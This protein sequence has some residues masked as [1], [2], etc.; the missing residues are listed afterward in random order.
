MTK[1]YSIQ[2]K[3][4]A[5]DQPKAAEIFIYGDIGESWWGESVTAAE[6]VKEIAALDADE[7]TVRINSYGGSVSDGVAIYNAIKRHKARVTIAIDGVAISIASLI[8][9]AGDTVE[10]A[11]NALMM[12]HAPWGSATGNSADMRDMADVLDKYAQAMATS[13]AAKSGKSIDDV[14]ALLSDGADHWLTATEAQADGYVDTVTAA[15]A[16]AASFDR[17]AFAARTQSLPPDAGRETPAAA[18]ATTQEKSMNQKTTPAADPQPAAT[19]NAD[20]I[21]AAAIKAEADRR[22][23]IDL[24]FSKFGHVAGMTD[25]KAACHKDTACTVEAAKLQIL[26]KIST[27]ATPAAGGHV[28]TVEDERD[29]FRAGAQAA[30][31]ARAGLAK[32]DTAN[33]FRGHTLLE[34]ARASLAKSGVR[35]DGM[36]KM[37]VVAAAFTHSTSD[38]DS[39]LANTANKAMLKGYEEAEETFQKWTSVGNLPDFKAA[40]RVDLNTF[41]SL[42]V[43]PEGAEYKSATFGDR[44]ETVQ[45]AT[46]G[47]KFS[48][49]RQAI[50]NDDLDAFSKIPRNMGRAA[51]R[52]VGNL[53]YAVLTANAAMADGVAL[54]HADHANLL[55]GAAI[56]T[57]SVDALAAAMRK[58]KDATGNTLNIRL[59]YLLVPVSLEGLA[60]TVAN[61]EFEVGTLDTT[62]KLSGKNNTVPNIMRGRFEVIGD[63]RLDDTST[64][65][66]YGAANAASH[67]TIEVSYLDGVQTPVLE[68]QGGWDADGV[69]FKVRL[70]AGVKALDHRTLAK[71][72]GA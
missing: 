12:I 63:A 35:T 58:Q 31:M 10:M 51:I 57:T 53:V 67:D 13:Y 64:S 71:N 45:L 72:P 44:G 42:L 7:L 36:G 27:G 68:Q 32:D 21:R 25:L 59:G 60:L 37:E 3:A 41:P 55:T 6:F 46:Y 49:T 28:V 70:D 22:D 39:I 24:A 1:F 34:L 48:I 9:M 4:R 52:T 8:A 29:K 5:A 18:A 56:S 33:N 65:V 14:L 30:I 43:V 38:F 20:D 11:D 17:E 69:E 15:L 26:D 50:I 2:A 62:N 47:R 19:I 23:G 66:W 54:F 40:K 16:V 61:S